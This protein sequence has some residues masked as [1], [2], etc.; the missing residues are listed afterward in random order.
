MSVNG[1]SEGSERKRR[2]AEE[3]YR[4]DLSARV[5]V[6]ERSNLNLL[7]GS[8]LFAADREIKLAPAPESSRALK[9]NQSCW[10]DEAERSTV[11]IGADDGEYV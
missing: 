6:V 10:V 4:E 2:M 5:S 1:A 3:A 9:E 8:S 7:V 11:G